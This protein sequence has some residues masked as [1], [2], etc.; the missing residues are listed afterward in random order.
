L[1]KTGD[2]GDEGHVGDDDSKK[3]LPARDLDAQIGQRKQQQ[4]CYEGK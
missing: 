1:K 2:E 4:D 3:H